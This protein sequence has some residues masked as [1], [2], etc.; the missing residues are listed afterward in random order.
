MKAE[1]FLQ[2][3]KNNFPQISWEKY[4]ILTHGF[5]HVVIILDEKIIFRFPK[6]KEY[7]SEFENETQLLNYLKKKVKVGI[8]EYTYISKNK[9]LAGYKILSGRELTATRFRKLSVLEKEKLAK[10]IADFLTSL[11]TTTK[12]IITK[13]NIHTENPRKEH[14]KFVRDTKKLVFPRLNKKEVQIIENYFSEL[15][16]ALD[17][18]FS[19]AL[20]HNDLT[21]A[22]ILWDNKKNQV[23]IIDFSDRAF[24]DPASDFAGLWEYGSKFVKNV[25]RLY[26]GKKDN[27]LLYRSQL[28]FKRIPLSDMKNSLQGYP[29]EFKQGYNLFKKVFKI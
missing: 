21:S 19:N 7:K 12:S 15:K 26:Q 9:S 22:H 13:Y 29:R 3:I 27:T 11:H 17:H 1:S 23:N 10:Q 24:G 5:D 2:K 20:L 8:P 18:T 14:S 28:Y 6:A 16:N 4:R 25:Y